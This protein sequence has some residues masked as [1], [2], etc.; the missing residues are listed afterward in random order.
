M[1]FLLWFAVVRLVWWISEVSELMDS[2]V[3]VIPGFV[4]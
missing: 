4:N 2:R 3:F 1:I